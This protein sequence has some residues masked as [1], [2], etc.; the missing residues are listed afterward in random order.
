MSDTFQTQTEVP[1]EDNL[2][3]SSSE[4]TNEEENIE[5]DQHIEAL[6]DWL[7]S[8]DVGFLGHVKQKNIATALYNDGWSSKETLIDMYSSGDLTESIL[9]THI[10][11]RGDRAKLIRALRNS[12]LPS[13]S[14]FRNNLAD[15]TNVD[16]ASFVSPK[17]V[18]M[19]YSWAQKPIVI[20]LTS[21]LRLLGHDIWRDEDGS[22][23]LGSME[24]IGGIY[25]G[26]SQAVESSN[27]SI[28][29]VSREYSRSRNCIREYNYLSKR[30]IPI[31]WV[32]M[33]PDFTPASS[34]FQGPIPLLMEDSLYFQLFPESD[35]PTVTERISNALQSAQSNAG[36]KVTPSTAQTINSSPTFSGTLMRC[37]KWILT[38]RN[39]YVVLV[40][41][42]LTVAKYAETAPHDSIFCQS[43]SVQK[44]LNVN[45]LV[46]RGEGR[47]VFYF[48]STNEED[49]NRWKACI[50]ACLS[51]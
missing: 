17:H 29:C 34:E 42:V 38:W 48:Q 14:P 1:D 45:T 26:M 32:L 23:V 22:E 8:P 31:I 16:Q 5:R 49:F 9:E 2:D 37:S 47:K 6:M 30:N 18:M 36:R 46:V 43:V 28:V 41:R 44:L 24:D 10:I 19:S 39:R 12:L 51:T 4:P 3:I 40:G 15:A 27:C 33:Q 7:G 13:N 11:T 20:E 25:D 21:G 35:L 50:E